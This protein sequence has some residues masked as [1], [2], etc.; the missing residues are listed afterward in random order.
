M[1]YP[2]R[3]EV[4][5]DSSANRAY[6]KR[7]EILEYELRDF[8]KGDSIEK[9]SNDLKNFASSIASDE[10]GYTLSIIW[11]KKRPYWVK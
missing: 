6:R 8:W 5:E 10:S 3:D 9:Y 2:D 4:S 11:G 1:S 7:L